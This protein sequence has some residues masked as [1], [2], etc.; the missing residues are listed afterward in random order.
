M[1]L[2]THKILKID[3]ETVVTH[4]KFERFVITQSFSLKFNFSS[5]EH[6]KKVFQDGLNLI[7]L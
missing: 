2:F 4:F 5:F 3:K 1:E 6:V 7:I